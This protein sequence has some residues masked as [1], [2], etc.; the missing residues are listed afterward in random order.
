MNDREALSVLKIHELGSVTAAAEALHISQ[1]ALSRSLINLEKRLGARI[2]DRTT[3]PLTLTDFG[4]EYVAAA[5]SIATIHGDMLAKL[6]DIKD[7]KAGQLRIGIPLTRANLYLPEVLPEFERKYPRVTVNIFEDTTSA[8]EARLLKGLLDMMIVFGPIDN[9][10]IAFET[11]Q[12]EKMLLVT[13]PGYIRDGQ[14]CRNFKTAIDRLTAPKRK[15]LLLRKGQ[16]LRQVAEKV[17]LDYGI[18]P[19]IEERTRSIE[20]VLKLCAKG[21]GMTF[22]TDVTRKAV[23]YAV[24]PDY[25]PLTDKYSIPV[26]AAYRK[27]GYVPK[28]GKVFIA[29]LQKVFS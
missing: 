19:I 5:Q 28:A 13:P 2:F 8:L 27:D 7:M 23:P 22:T 12:W 14:S 29:M 24:K 18:D 9:P 21:M 15:F 10:A 3:S 1:P 11:I 6:Q 25:Y 26:V 17:F 20:T 16:R 4:R